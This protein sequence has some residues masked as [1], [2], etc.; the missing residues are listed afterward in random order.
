[1]I[2][3]FRHSDKKRAGRGAFWLAG[4][5]DRRS[6]PAHSAIATWS[7]LMGRE[8][9]VLWLDAKAFEGRGR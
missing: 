1:M 2:R 4:Q 9:A 3:M 7:E 6:H 8:A 5:F